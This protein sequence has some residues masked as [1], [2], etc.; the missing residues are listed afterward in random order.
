MFSS[1]ITFIIFANNE[2]ARIEPMLK[3][4]Q[5]H[6]KIIVIDNYSFDNTLNIAKKYTNEIYQ[7]KNIG[8]VENEQTMEFALSKIKTKWA[9]LA[10]VD[11]LIPQSLM[12]LLKKVAAEDRYDIVEIY[13]RNFMYGQEVFNY[14]KHHLRMFV[15]DSV[16]F[17]GNIVHKLG[18]HKVGTDRVLRIPKGAN[19]SIWHFSSYNTERLELT[20]NRYAN[21]EA[22]QR[23]EVLGQK[24]SGVRA[25]FKLLFYFFGTYIGLGGFRGGWPGLFVSLQIAYFKFSIEARLW[26]FDNGVSLQNIEKKYAS[27][28]EQLLNEY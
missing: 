18:K 9:Y 16:D 1:N 12:E 22:L 7:H 23:H 27:L 11:E 6:G 3:C 10:Y 14:G 21:L 20:H 5:G 28:K 19:T 26:E 25:I 24:F 2:E 15:K 13:R 17:S 4:L 8:Y